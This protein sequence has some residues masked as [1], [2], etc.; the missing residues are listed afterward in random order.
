MEKK[1]NFNL[2]GFLLSLIQYD[3]HYKS[4]VVQ[5][6]ELGVGSNSNIN[7]VKEGTWK[8]LKSWIDNQDLRLDYE[9]QAPITIGGLAEKC[10]ASQLISS[11]G[12]RDEK[13]RHLRENT[14]NNS[15]VGYVLALWSIKQWQ[16]EF[17]KQG[18]KPDWNLQNLA[19]NV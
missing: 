14:E 10:K 16:L 12:R 4:W 17:E 13:A 7:N 15:G 8:N 2:N 3:W 5:L 6:S 9:A 1:M 18:L 19:K 11:D